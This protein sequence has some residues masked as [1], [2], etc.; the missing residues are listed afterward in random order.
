VTEAEWLAYNEPLQLLDHVI[1]RAS[2]RQLRLLACACCRRLW[3]AL[4]EEARLTVEVAERYAD[5]Q[6]GRKELSGTK[7]GYYSAVRADNCASLAARPSQ[8]FR[9]Q[10]RGVVVQAVLSASADE[11]GWVR[12]TVPAIEAAEKAA[13]SALVRDV[14]GARFRPVAVDPAWLKW[15]R[16]AVAQLARRCYEE[17][18][19]PS[20]LLSPQRLAVLADALLEANCDSAELLGHLRDPGPHVRGCWGVDLLLGKG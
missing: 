15:D 19:L 16:G 10:V 1:D 5:G 12:R 18:E 11:D 6:A 20:G 14:L 8:G 2:L 9:R 4:S 3:A 7:G 13:L 17:R